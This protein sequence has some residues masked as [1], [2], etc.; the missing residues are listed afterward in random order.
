MPDSDKN[1]ANNSLKKNKTSKL[2]EVKLHLHGEV[3]AGLK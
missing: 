1:I 3:S 2:I